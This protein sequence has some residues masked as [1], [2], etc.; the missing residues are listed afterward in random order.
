MP[1]VLTEILIGEPLGDTIGRRTTS[2]CAGYK[3]PAPAGVWSPLP[4][5]SNRP[6]SSLTARR[7]PETCHQLEPGEGGPPCP[8]RWTSLC[9]PPPQWAVQSAWIETHAHSTAKHHE[10]S[11]GRHP[12]KPFPEGE[13]VHR[14]GSCCARTLGDPG[15]SLQDMAWMDAVCAKR[16]NCHRVALG[17]SNV[18]GCPLDRLPPDECPA[19]RTQRSARLWNRLVSL[20]VKEAW[21]NSTTNRRVDGVVQSEDRSIRRV[22]CRGL[23]DLEVC[24]HKRKTEV[25]PPATLCLAPADGVGR[26]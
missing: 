13:I 24:H 25:R 15:M 22:A 23:T 1:C 7:T 8:L 19:K 21:I 3:F 5:Q 11:T 20:F 17:R 2:F 6:A 26:I 9:K 14:P 12:R 4:T 18:F 16:A 10:K